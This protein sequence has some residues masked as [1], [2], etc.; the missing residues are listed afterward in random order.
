[1]FQNYIYVCIYV[2]VTI[3]TG[4]YIGIPILS[5]FLASLPW[6]QNKSQQLVLSL[7]CDNFFCCLCV[8]VCDKIFIFPLSELCLSLKG[9]SLY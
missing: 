5:L 7:F 4:T 9:C 2:N 1:M 8:C 6:T 3:N